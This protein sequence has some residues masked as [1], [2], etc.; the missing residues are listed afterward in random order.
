M[1]LNL[2]DVNLYYEIEGNGPFLFIAQ[3]G[4]GDARRTSQLVDNLK[5]QFTVVTYDRRGLSRTEFKKNHEESTLNN[6]SN[7]LY[8][9]ISSLSSTPV[10]VLGC[11][12]GA[13][14][15]LN[16]S[17]RYKN[18]IKRI[19]AHEPI[20]P[21]ILSEKDRKLHI[22]ELEE[23]REIYLHGAWMDGI[24]KM[25]AVL[26]INP[27]SQT[28]EADALIEPM[29]LE[30][31]PNFDF[32]IKYDFQSI[33]DFDFSLSK[34][35]AVEEHTCIIPAVGKETNQSVFDYKCSQIIANALNKDLTYFP[36]GHNGNTTHPNGYAEML[37]KLLK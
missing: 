25:A 2:S 21:S 34:I 12:I 24:K 18:I 36:G 3:S 8:E 35:K 20:L 29:T 16:T 27:H 19:V 33:I 26:G 10:D 4:E 1:F 22:S 6:H 5:R 9:L 28:K 17:Y 15:A 7:D 23:I 31:K 13:T 37:Q 14:I 32:F 30:R 11:S